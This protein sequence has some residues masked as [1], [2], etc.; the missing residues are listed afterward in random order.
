MSNKLSIRIH[1]S[2][3]V[4]ELL[5]IL[6]PW[7]GVNHLFQASR[8]YVASVEDFHNFDLLYLIAKI[9]ESNTGIIPIYTFSNDFGEYY[10]YLTLTFDK[11]WWIDQSKYQ[12]TA[13]ISAKIHGGKGTVIWT[14]PLP[15]EKA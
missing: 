15:L 8:E 4:G 9:V 11:L 14:S 7:H 2:S 1:E 5:E 6:V 13:S 12:V 3:D 10:G